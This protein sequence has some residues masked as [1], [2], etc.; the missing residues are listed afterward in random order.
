MIYNITY[1]YFQTFED[2]F[3][4][5]YFMV[6]LSLLKLLQLY[7]SFPTLTLFNRVEMFLLSFEKIL[8]TFH[9]ISAVFN[10]L[11]KNKKRKISFSFYITVVMAKVDLTL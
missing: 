3:A 11:N 7:T 2:K 9:Q 4:I 10:C 8:S 1:I 6:K 5:F